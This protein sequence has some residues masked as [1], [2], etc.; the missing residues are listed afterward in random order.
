MERALA[1]IIMMAVSVA[2]LE[3]VTQAALAHV[4]PTKPEEL[5]YTYAS[6]VALSLQNFTFS[7]DF[8]ERLSNKV[9]ELTNASL[10]LGLYREAAY[11]LLDL[12]VLGKGCREREG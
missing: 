9:A 5:K 12:A 2:A 3:N 7:S 10:R 11:G 1:L 4:V 8:I 6:L